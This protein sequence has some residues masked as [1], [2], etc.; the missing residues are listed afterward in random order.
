M[1]ILSMD[2]CGQVWVIQQKENKQND[3][4]G[5]FSSDTISQIS[6]GKND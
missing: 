1:G 6:V 5:F 3:Q 2:V 4:P